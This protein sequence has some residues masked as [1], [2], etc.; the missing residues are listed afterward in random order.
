MSSS[1]FFK[2]GSWEDQDVRPIAPMVM[3]II[4]MK[5]IGSVAPVLTAG[6]MG[7]VTEILLLSCM[8]CIGHG[9]TG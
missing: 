4:G 9:S 1:L 8:C 7:V 3:P 5:A 2:H 6:A